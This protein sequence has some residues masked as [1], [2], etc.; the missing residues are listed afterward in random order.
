M[1]GLEVVMLVTSIVSA[2]SSTAAYL[3]ARRRKKKNKARRRHI[4]LGKLRDAVN[5]A[6]S[7]IQQEYDHNFERIG[8]E[9]AK[10]DDIARAQLAEV[11]IGLQQNMIAEL[12]TLLLRKSRSENIDYSALIELSESS[13]LESIS[14]LAQQYQRFKTA[15]PIARDIVGAPTPPSD[16]DAVPMRVSRPYSYTAD[17]LLDAV[18]VT[19]D[20]TPSTTVDICSPAPETAPSPEL[21]PTPFPPPPPPPPPTNTI[22]ASSCVRGS[23]KTKRGKRTTTSWDAAL[24]NFTRLLNSSAIGGRTEVT[25]GKF[26][27]WRC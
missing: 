26:K 6:P 5:A 12:Q 16:E 1:S 22:A 2:Y 11:L 25:Q 23:G 24:A 15:A 8:P 19:A 21:S 3:R 4:A 17:N 27:R 9:F 10:G 13:K 7:E 18:T 14:A 20:A